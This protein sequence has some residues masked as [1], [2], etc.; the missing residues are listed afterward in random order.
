MVPLSE[1]SRA[2]LG[3]TH[4]HVEWIPC[5]FWEEREAD[6]LYHLLSMLK[7]TNGAIPPFPLYAFMACTGIKLFVLTRVTLRRHTT[8]R[9]VDSLIPLCLMF[10]SIFRF[11][12]SSELYQRS[13]LSLGLPLF[14]FPVLSSPLSLSLSLSLLH[15]PV[16]STWPRHSSPLLYTLCIMPAEPIFPD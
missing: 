13:H 3:P 12:C 15:P 4:F 11:L 2:V 9:I 8:C 1:I 6:R 10:Y 14:V 7:K 5:T 16:L